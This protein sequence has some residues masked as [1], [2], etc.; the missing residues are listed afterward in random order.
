MLKDSINVQKV[1]ADPGIFML[2]MLGLT[3][4]DIYA[5]ESVVK[6]MVDVIEVHVISHRVGSEAALIPAYL[7]QQ[8]ADTISNC[9]YTAEQEGA[10]WAI[11]ATGLHNIA[12]RVIEREERE[13]ILKMMGLDKPHNKRNQEEDSANLN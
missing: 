7:Y 13:H 1:M 10:L 5:L 3:K 8:L 4:E 12:E 6:S 9:G 2:E 11:A